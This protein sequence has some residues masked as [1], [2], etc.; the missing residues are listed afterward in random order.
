[1]P[2]SLS[3]L[4][5]GGIADS[6]KSVL[7]K[8][9]AEYASDIK[10]FPISEFLRDALA[11]AHKNPLD[12]LGAE[13]TL[14]DWK[15]HEPKAIDGLVA[16]IKDCFKDEAI[17]TVVIN[18]HFATHSPG[19][20]MAGLDPDS[21]DRI[22]EACHLAESQTAKVAVVLV[23]IGLADVLQWRGQHWTS[24]NIDAFAT[25]SELMEDLEFNRV[26]A[27][28]YYNVLRTTVDKER[29]LYH[30]VFMDRSKFA[31]LSELENQAEFQLIF[32]KFTD[33]LKAN[34]FTNQTKG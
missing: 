18:T 27:L 26:Y 6:G 1:M 3:L 15:T 32:N 21:I 30:R 20:S 29:V 33:F 22:C 5:I 19:G 11:A 17:R 23:D 7:V 9:L 31:Q 28:H 10:L 14:I 13:V 25:G 8:K 16:Q 24:N 12:K 34:E 4:F 2:D